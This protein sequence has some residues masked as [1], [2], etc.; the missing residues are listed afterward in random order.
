MEPIE[1]IEPIEPTEP[2]EPSVFKILQ[3][4]TKSGPMEIRPRT[5]PNPFTSR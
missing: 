4:L 3:R 5:Q 1:P 2:M